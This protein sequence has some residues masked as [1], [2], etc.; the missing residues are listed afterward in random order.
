MHDHAIKNKSQGLLP[1]TDLFHT[2]I[3]LSPSYFF[4]FSLAYPVLLALSISL[5]VLQEYEQMMSFQ[6]TEEML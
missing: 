2:A 6:L 1:Y 5:E 4:V 3:D